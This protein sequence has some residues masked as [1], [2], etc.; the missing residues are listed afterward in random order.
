MTNEE[1][2][3]VLKNFLKENNIKFYNGYNGKKLK[4]LPDLYIPK[5]RIMV[6][7]SDANDQEFYNSVKYGWHPLFIRDEESVDFVIEKMQNLI[8]GIMNVKHQL[9]QKMVTR[10]AK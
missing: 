4:I 2:L 3:E 6:K 7:I 9:H 5:H 1:K 10:K 8:I